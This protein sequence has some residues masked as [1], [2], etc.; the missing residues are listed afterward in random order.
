MLVGGEEFK[1]LARKDLI[2]VLK[3]QLKLMI[4]VHS[5]GNDAV[6]VSVRSEKTILKKSM[7]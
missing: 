3:L 7:K 5:S 1:W 6:I 4:K 2:L